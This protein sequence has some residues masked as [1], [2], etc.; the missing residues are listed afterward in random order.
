MCIHEHFTT[1]RP[2]KG[3]LSKETKMRAL[4]HSA[5]ETTHIYYIDAPVLPKQS[6]RRDTI[7]YHVLL[8][9]YNMEND[10]SKAWCK[11]AIPKA[12]T[13]DDEAKLLSETPTR[14]GVREWSKQTRH[15]DL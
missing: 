1:T 2:Y 9:V 5:E 6:T 3:L 12:S 15:D 11:Q 14:E 10:D 7:D 8:S 4:C 13:E